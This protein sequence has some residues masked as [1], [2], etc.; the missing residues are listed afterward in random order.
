[1]PF[2]SV[3]RDKRWVD[4]RGGKVFGED[5]ILPLPCKH[6]TE[7]KKCRIHETKPD[8]CKAFPMNFGPQAWLFNMGCKF[9][10]G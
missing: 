5:V 8:F 3:S 1:M 2:S 10:G 7:D 9:Y 4:A 6:L